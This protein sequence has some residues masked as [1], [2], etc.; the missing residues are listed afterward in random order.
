[1]KKLPLS[2]LRDNPYYDA[3][4]Y[5]D[6]GYI[7]LLSGSDVAVGVALALQALGMAITPLIGANRIEH[8]ARVLPAAKPIAAS[9]PC[10]KPVIAVPE[11]VM[12]P[13]RRNSESSSRV[14]FSF[15]GVSP[16]SMTTYA[17]K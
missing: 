6:E 14:C 5:L 17:S 2:E 11:I 16:G 4:V 12:R 13:T 15:S 3:P 1:M 9:T 7:L 8:R 10:A